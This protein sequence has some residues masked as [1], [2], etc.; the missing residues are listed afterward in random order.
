MTLVAAALLGTAQIAAAAPTVTHADAI[1]N[2]AIEKTN[3][4]GPVAQW[5]KVRI[6]GDWSVPTGSQAG[7]T[8]GMT[9]PDEFSRSGGGS[10]DIADPDSGV[11][12]AQCQIAGGN[13]PELVCTLT[14]AVEDMENPGGSFWVEVTASQSNTSGTVEFDLGSTVEIVTLP[15]GGGITPEDLTEAGQPYKYGGPTAT[16]GLLSW[17]VGI[18]SSAV[19]DGGFVVRDSLDRDLEYHHYTGEARLL[20]RP[21]QDGVLVGNW[22]E[23]DTSR[24]Q[25]TFAPDDLSF[26]FTASGLPSSGM[27][28]RLQYFTQADGIVQAGDVFGNSATVNSSDTSARVVVTEA[29]GGSGTGARFTRFEITKA[30][31]GEQADAARG[32]TFTVR[33][34]IKG[35]DAPAK[36]LSVPVGQAVRSDRAPL[37]STF[38]VEEIDL[39][40][41]DGVTWGDWSITGE[42]VTATGDGRYEVTPSTTAGVQ[43]TLTNQANTT[44]VVGSLS[45]QK[46][47]RDGAAL[48]GSE[49]LVWGRTGTSRWSTAARAMRLTQTACSASA[50]YLRAPTRSPRPR[51]RRGTSARTRRSR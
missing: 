10:F 15:G 2:L 39:P 35:S 20:Q 23:V 41:I 34:S 50:G 9:L 24:Y 44:P 43:F 48:A 47:D 8:F 31:S 13:G 21:V 5:E 37:G 16:D 12:L 32:A 33:Y 38:I 45:W 1:S 36:T 42:G 18:P 17:V 46:V 19:R 27:S 6:T 11:V 25:M 26:E 14:A 7:D 29:G 4:S 51:R 40:T 28:Y 49:W 22:T 3:G 30:L